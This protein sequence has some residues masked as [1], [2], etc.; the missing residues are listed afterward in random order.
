MTPLNQE[1]IIHFIKDKQLPKADVDSG[2]GQIGTHL[3]VDDVEFPLFFRIFEGSTMLQCIAFIPT[4]LEQRTL[5]GTARL[6]HMINKEI[7]LPGF[8]MD[9]DSQTVFFRHMLPCP[10]KTF[11]S[12]LLTMVIDAIRLVCQSFGNP[13]AAVAS[14]AVPFSEVLQKSK[15]AR[16]P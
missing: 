8:G 13:I 4:K 7:D 11:D 14:G 16:K 2:S 6:L 1:K 9:E 15:D 5:S 3:R 10:S 12:E